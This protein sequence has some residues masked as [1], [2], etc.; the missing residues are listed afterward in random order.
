MT[1]FFDLILIV[2]IACFLLKLLVLYLVRMQELEL[3]GWDC[4]K[5]VMLDEY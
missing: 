4:E 5:D 1:F 2:R 3:V